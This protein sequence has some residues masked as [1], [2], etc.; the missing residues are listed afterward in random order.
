MR[1]PQRNRQGLE[2]LTVPPRKTRGIFR[3]Q[4]RKRPALSIRHCLKSLLSLRPSSSS[5]RRPIRVQMS[6]ASRLSANQARFLGIG[7]SR[8]GR[9][10]DLKSRRSL[11]SRGGRRAV[12]QEVSSRLRSQSRSLWTTRNLRLRLRSRRVLPSIATQAVPLKETCQGS[13]V[14]GCS[15]QAGKLTGLL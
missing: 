6:P 10:R 12:S 3:S 1:R 7:T 11:K 13:V 4:G 5:T 14:Q 15:R 9:Q 8:S 2:A